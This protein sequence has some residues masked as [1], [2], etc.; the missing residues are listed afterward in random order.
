MAI[1]ERSSRQPN[2][3]TRD[4]QHLHL[5]LPCLPN[6]EVRN[7]RLLF[8]NHLVCS[9]LTARMDQDTA[10]SA[11]WLIPVAQLKM[12]RFREV[13]RLPSGPTAKRWGF[14]PT[15]V[16]RDIAHGKN[17]MTSCKTKQNQAHEFQR[18]TEC[19][20]CAPELGTQN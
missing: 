7:E 4:Q 19:L 14:K 2:Q 11:G 17:V 9:V 10:L 18:H 3:Q 12:L 6:R 15:S 5:G 1:L 8:T 16:W 13:L 20:L